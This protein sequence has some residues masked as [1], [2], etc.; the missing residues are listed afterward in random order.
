MPSSRLLKGLFVP[1]LVFFSVSIVLLISTLTNS[2]IFTPGFAKSA[3]RKISLTS[4]GGGDDQGLRSRNNQ[5]RNE[6]EP[7]STSPPLVPEPPTKSGTGTLTIK[8]IVVNDGGGNRR[9]SDFTI[10]VDGNNPTP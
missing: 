2:S 10:N 4:S 8:K 6:T 7:P 1:L 9:P 5:L 3:D